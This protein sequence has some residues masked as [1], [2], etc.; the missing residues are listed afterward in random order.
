MVKYEYFLQHHM[1]ANMIEKLKKLS[2]FKTKQ[3]FFSN[4]K[5][6]N[7]IFVILFLFILILALSACSS[8][9]SGDQDGFTPVATRMPSSTPS[10]TFTPTTTSTATPTQTPT[11]TPTL[12]IPVLENT[13][14]PQPAVTISAGN[15]NQ[16]QPLAVWGQGG[17][18]SPVFSLDKSLVA[19]AE[20]AGAVVFD[21]KTLVQK[22]RV[23]TGYTASSVAISQD[24]SLLA[25]GTVSGD[26]EIFRMI[27]GTQI[28]HFI[29]DSFPVKW[30][31]FGP[32]RLMVY[33]YVILQDDWVNTLTVWDTS[34][35]A[36][37]FS[38]NA[39]EEANNTYFYDPITSPDGSLLVWANNLI[40]T[41]NGNNIFMFEGRGN[42]FSDDGSLLVIFNDKN[43]IF[44]HSTVDG[45]VVQSLK[46]KFVS[47]TPDNLQILAVTGEGRIGLFDID[48]P[49]T[50][51]QSFAGY[52]FP[53]SNCKNCGIGHKQHGLISPD[54]QNLVLAE[55]FL[56]IYET[57]NAILIYDLESG[58]LERNIPL[59]I[60]VN[61]FYSQFGGYKDF[62]SPM[63]MVFLDGGKTML[64]IESTQGGD[65]PVMMRKWDFSTGELL[66]SLDLYTYIYDFSGLAFSPDNLQ[67][68]VT[69]NSLN[70]NTYTIDKIDLKTGDTLQSL[71]T[72]FY[73]P[74]KGIQIF[75][76][77]KML[78]ANNV[79]GSSTITD[80]EKGELSLN[81]LNQKGLNCT[82]RP[83]Q[84]EAPAA[85][86]A[87]D[88]LMAC[89]T[90]GP[91][92]NE[93]I[94]VINIADQ[95]EIAQITWRASGFSGIRDVDFS[96]D[97]QLLAVGLDLGKSFVIDIK[98][99]NTI[100]NFLS[101]VS[102]L[103]FSPDSSI[104]VVNT[105]Y[106]GYFFYDSRTGEILRTIVSTNFGRNGRAGISFSPDGKWM[107]TGGN[108]GI[109]FW[110]IR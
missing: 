70:E 10:L 18:N 3:L 37:V 77:G 25:V 49:G 110:G 53:A 109:T 15:I 62:L 60:G 86:S 1:E 61:G 69:R 29:K 9:P 87:D 27:D 8:S 93:K 42:A 30:V 31:G 52:P 73:S 100:Y 54:G 33:Q 106:D 95:K 85:I 39:D 20:S 36:E 46:G 19:F 51:R 47:L 63:E 75:N 17:F 12:R 83:D 65:H 21:T 105:F 45:S 88:K 6:T 22:L 50:L 74:I 72:S 92:F 84:V 68:Y 14:L 108:A 103:A 34:T 78:L 44:V 91:N 23:I 67:I 101:G 41:I 55:R 7:Q 99:G 48:Q 97:G 94:E 64:T 90:P 107:V 76:N 28:G 16:V 57:Q 81:D 11:S 66:A 96:P 43:Q 35:G 102:N 24:N 79:Y 38:I 4:L 58:L 71:P 104:L 80:V 26:I 2:R 40:S 32:D 5:W 89:Y 56:Q 59:L 98:S 82:T 13:P